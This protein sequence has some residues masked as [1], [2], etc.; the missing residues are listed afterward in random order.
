MTDVVVDSS[1]VGKWLFPEVDS[2]RAEQILLGVPAKG[3]RL[4]VLDLALVEMTNAIWKRFCRGLASRED[5]SESLET[6][7]GFPL[8][9]EP[10][11]RLLRPGL[12]IAIQY[13]LAVYDALFVALVQNL[14]LPGVTADE[15]LYRAVHA[16]FP[17]IVLLRDWGLAP[18]SGP[19]PAA[20]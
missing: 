11:N 12:E 2:V 3:H 7:F 8:T 17:Q 16:A 5:A 10:A 13:R 6:L 9:V 19:P 4:V 1:V 18:P 14:G 15:P 20:P